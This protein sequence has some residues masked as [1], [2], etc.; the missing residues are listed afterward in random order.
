MVRIGITNLMECGHDML[1]CCI[2]RLYPYKR[3][4]KLHIRGR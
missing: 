2:R 3:E 4:F 1:G